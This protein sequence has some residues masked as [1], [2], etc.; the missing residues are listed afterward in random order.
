MKSRLVEEIQKKRKEAPY[1]ET[2]VQNAMKHYFKEKRN[3]L[4]HTFFT[5]LYRISLRGNKIGNKEKNF[6]LHCYMYKEK[7]RDQSRLLILTLHTN[8]IFKQY[9]GY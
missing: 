2:K 7:P 6:F 5:M 4:P 8:Y 1:R 3:L 9:F